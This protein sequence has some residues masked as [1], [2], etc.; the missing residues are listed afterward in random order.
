M[1]RILIGYD[2]ST[3]ADTALDDLRRAGLPDEAE[4][5]VVSVADVMMDHTASSYEVVE[6]A[7]TSRRVSSG[8]LLAQKQSARVGLEAKAFAT[9]A[10]E[11]LRSLFPNWHVSTEALAGDPSQ[12]LIMKADEWKPDLIVVGSHGYSLAGRLILGSVFKKL[13]TDSH[14]SVRVTRGKAKRDDFKPIRVVIGVDGSSEADL[15]TQRVTAHERVAWMLRSL[16]AE[17][18][19][20]TLETGA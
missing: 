20:S 10:G 19:P 3:G 6:Q 14:H 15:L 2:G 4:A 18:R 17:Q 16:L 9:K 7:L 1:M 8:L 11:R 13:V 12:E 5:L